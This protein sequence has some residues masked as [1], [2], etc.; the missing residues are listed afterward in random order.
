MLCGKLSFL[1]PFRVSLHALHIEGILEAGIAPPTLCTPYL[2]KPLPLQPPL[3]PNKGSSRGSPQ[4]RSL[5]LDTYCPRLDVKRFRL[6]DPS[7]DFTRNSR[8][9]GRGLRGVLSRSAKG[10]GPGVED[11]AGWEARSGDLFRQAFTSGSLNGLKALA[12][13]CSR[14]PLVSE[15]W[16]AKSLP[17]RLLSH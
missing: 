8:V 16:L 1:R 9:C 12:P 4:L 13:Y 7:L 10:Q 17:R 3:P 15:R 14:P 2:Q 11:K 6:K 5:M